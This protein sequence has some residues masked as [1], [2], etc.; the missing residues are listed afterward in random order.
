MNIKNFVF[1]SIIVICI[2]AVALALA[3]NQQYSSGQTVYVKA[4]TENLR[5][6]PQGN[7]LGTVDKATSLVVLED[8]GQWTKVRLEGWI[9]KASLTESKLALQ[10]DVYRAQQIVVKELSTAEK[11][12]KR[13]KSGEDFSAVAKKLSIGPAA[14]KGGDLGYF[15]KGDFQPEVEKA[16]L[17]LQPGQV[18][19]IVKSAAGY[20]IF[21]RTE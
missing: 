18:S 2:A 17:S 11:A 19:E 3:F 1:G 21:K 10:G 8:S 13:V 5:D 14:K 6:A 7:K 20:H 16:I 15:K 9:W 4:A 12:L